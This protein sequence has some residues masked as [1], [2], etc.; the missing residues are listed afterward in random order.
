MRSAPTNDPAIFP[1]GDGPDA[2]EDGLWR[3]PLPLPFALRSVNVYLAADG[4][5]GWT[6]FDAGLGLP[7]DEVALRA[8]LATAG[9]ALED[10]TALVL[11]HAHPDHI[12]LA[13]MIVAASGCP[14]YMF[15]RE[16]ERMY[17]VWGSYDEE[18]ATDQVIPALQ[19]MYRAH[20]LPEDALATVAPSTL[21]MRRILR[22]P[23]APSIIAVA[24]GETLTLGGRRH[25]A[26]W[27]PG[28]ADYHLCLL[29]DDEVFFVGDH[30]LPAIT[31]NIGVYPDAR[32][33]PLR[34]YFE[35]LSRVRTAQARLVLPGHGHPFTDATTRVDELRAHHEERSA[36]LMGQLAAHPAGAQAWELASALFAGRL[37]TS[38]D[39]RFAL[40]ETV[41][42]LEYLCGEGRVD[43]QR[44]SDV[45]SYILATRQPIVST[46]E[47]A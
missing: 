35:S 43:R 15:P 12:G 41:A 24:D 9:V 5:D 14:V 28:H 46:R 32:P 33:D 17:R 6:L 36:T 42:H 47:S 20:G 40:V 26:I 19:A 39:Q 11:T 44:Q 38:D 34:D 45:I 22:L 18:E 8:G 30:I 27:T 7:A 25:T 3:I 2:I 16:A 13:G 29:R 4:A 1:A 37:R 10:I 31:P 21:K 23:P